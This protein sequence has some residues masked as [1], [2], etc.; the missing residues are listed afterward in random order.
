VE[1]GAET[2][3]KAD[4]ISSLANSPSLRTAVREA[5]LAGKKREMLDDMNG[6]SEK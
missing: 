3:K 2:L 6:I 1:F 5:Y 4:S